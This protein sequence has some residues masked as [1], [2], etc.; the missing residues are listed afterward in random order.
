[1]LFRNLE[2][3][4]EQN[5]TMCTHGA[6]FRPPISKVLKTTTAQRPFRTL[7]IRERDGVRSLES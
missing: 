5:R 1:M 2:I 4:V 3:G 7:E 6:D